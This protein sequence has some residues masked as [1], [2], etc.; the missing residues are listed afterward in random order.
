M[1]VVVEG[2]RWANLNGSRGN[3]HAHQ[4][5]MDAWKSLAVL[6]IRRETKCVCFTRP[7]SITATVRRT[8]N[9]KADA[10]NVTPSIKACIDALVACG[11]IEDDHDGIVRRLV[12]EA[13]PKAPKPT[14]ELTVEPDPDPTHPRAELTIEHLEISD[15]WDETLI[16]PDKN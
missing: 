4:A 15:Q 6:A 2:T 1:K 3:P 11:V 10:H 7:V 12:I 14:I 13:G 8:R 9:G 5:L 16:P